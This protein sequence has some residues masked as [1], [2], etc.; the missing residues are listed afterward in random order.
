METCPLNPFQET[1]LLHALSTGDLSSTLQQHVIEFRQTED[2]NR[3]QDSCRMTVNEQPMLRARLR[4]GFDGF[5][6][7]PVESA[8]VPFESHDLPGVEAVDQAA[9]LE[10]FL[11]NDRTRGFRHDEEPLCRFNLIRFGK[12]QTALVWTVSSL[13]V[14]RASV[15]LVIRRILDFWRGSLTTPL[16]PEDVWL[17]VHRGSLPS[18][19]LDRGR[20]ERYWRVCLQGVETLSWLPENKEGGTEIE[21][22]TGRSQ[23][24]LDPETTR[25]LSELVREQSLDWATIAETTWAL[26]IQRYSGNSDVIFAVE[27]DLRRQG[28][29]PAAGVFSNLLLRRMSAPGDAAMLDWLRREQSQSAELLPYGLSRLSDVIHWA[30]LAR[31]ADWLT[32]L[33][34]VANP[35]IEESIQILKLTP[36]PVV[37]TRYEVPGVPVV[38]TLS[39]GGTADAPASRLRLDLLT[40]KRIDG[41][42]ADRLIGHWRFLL[43]QLAIN[44]SSPAA[45]LT[46]LSDIERNRVLMEWNRTEAPFSSDSCVHRLFDRQ[47]ALTPDRIAVSMKG[48]FLTYRRLNAYAEALAESLSARGIRK[49]SCVAICLPRSLELAVAVLGV[50]KSGGAYLPIDPA[51]PPDRI[52][53]MLK[54]SHAPVLITQKEL[55]EQL[56]EQLR[57]G[58]IEVFALESIRDLP[59][60]SSGFLPREEHSPE[61]LAYVIYTSG[62][63]GLPKGVGMTH[64]VLVNLIE[65]Q[66]K[67]ASFRLPE[68]AKTLQYSAL[69]FDVSFQEMF[70]TWCSGGQ[71]VLITEEIRRNP[72]AL[73]QV[74]AGQSIQRIF[75]PFIALQQLAEAAG[76][77]E[78]LPACLQEVITAGEQL[79]ITGQV[80]GLFRRLPQARLHNQYGPSETHVV[81]SLTLQ[82]D[83]AQWPALPSIGHPIDNARIYIL[84]HSRKPVPVGVAGEIYIGGNA[85]SR[86]YLNRPEATAERFLPDAFAGS[87]DARCYRTGDLGRFKPDGSIEFLG[88]ADDQVKIRGFRVELAEVEAALRQD[89]SIRD[90]VVNVWR[91]EGE[92]RLVAYV[93]PVSRDLFDE[94]QVRERIRSRMPDYMCPSLYMRLESL[95]LTPSGKVNRRGLPEPVPE[96]SF[97][98]VRFEPPQNAMEKSI[99]RIWQEV[100]GVS[101]VGRN[102]KFFDLGG[103]SLLMIR[104][105]RRLEEITGRSF[106]ITLLFQHPTVFSSAALLEAPDHSPSMK[107]SRRKELL[108]RA[109][110]QKQAMRRQAGRRLKGSVFSV[111]VSDPPARLI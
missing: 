13:L 60:E 70:A 20:M 24:D 62:S 89:P 10:S 80:A 102:D 53:W 98:S 97:L 76:V 96:R 100:L 63:T 18:L 34:R 16:N 74:I 44:P 57:M 36:E 45:D 109:E 67:Q 26:L 8:L 91:R 40:D 17:E 15:G 11:R 38:A 58:E 5:V 110:L 78:D 51:Y 42:T 21:R 107:D 47:A 75:L 69:S 88:R 2:G 61:Q 79:L 27:R 95:P 108:D 23:L 94:I 66:N 43:E 92:N 33:V 6:L 105:H 103:T 41:W 83:P 19:E 56:R 48:D 82:G 30:G 9:Q 55:R 31:E 90:C 73:W 14:D 68:G 84:D 54:D 28:L 85:V 59:Q 64:R 65:W 3:L 86:G 35:G 52:A 101:A 32:S 111:Q 7:E 87:P 93:L 104:V 50:L 29:Q 25:R 22:P 49:D 39:V 46:L 12:K 106:P 4:S 81:T 1:L 71:L 77:I 37:T 72:S 99:T